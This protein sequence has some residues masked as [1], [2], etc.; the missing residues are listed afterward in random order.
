MDEITPS[1]HSINLSTPQKEHIESLVEKNYFKSIDEF[2]DHAVR[3]LTEIYGIG[4]AEGGIKL[5]GIAIGKEISAASTAVVEEKPKTP[6]I[7]HHDEIIASFSSAK[8]EFEPALYGMHQMES[9]KMGKRPIPKDE[10]IEAL[11][12]MREAGI[13]ERLEREGKI[14]WKRTDS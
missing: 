7:T 5:P 8:Y 10:F 3:L 12:Q 2:I 13:I 6:E 14:I 1:S 11:E 4:E 9:M